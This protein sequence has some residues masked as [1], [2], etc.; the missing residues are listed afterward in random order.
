VSP[1]RRSR[2]A[3]LAC[4]L[5]LGCAIA[6]AGGTEAA[7]AT[8]TK[9][10]AETL[11]ALGDIASCTSQGDEQTAALL[12]R[13]PGT[14]AAIGDLAYPN[15]TAR[16]FADCFTPGWGPLVPRIRAAL[17]NHEYNSGTAAVAI[18]TFHLPQRGWYSYELGAWHVVVLNGN[19]GFVGGCATGS[20]QWRWM[21]ADLAAHRNTCTLA[22]WHQPRY[23]SGLH[24]SNDAYQ[25]FWDILAAAGA[26]LVLNGHDHDYERFAPIQGIREFVV[27][28]GGASHYPILLAQPHSV[29]RETG[30]FGVLRLSL[31][32]ASYTWKF[33]PVAGSTFTDAG[34]APCR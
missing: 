26:D 5:A 13:L 7:V 29:V 11:L 24:G 16:D 30:T 6:L 3:A 9:A 32:N 20:P 31:G 4:V 2:A 12:A 33:L 21:K 10:P 15:G 27:G 34:S 23:S 1:Q 14:I 18:R 28:T 19:C 17:G 8:G 22:Y 25:P